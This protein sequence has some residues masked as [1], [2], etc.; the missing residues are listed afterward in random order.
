VKVAS[1]VLCSQ[2]NKKYKI[3]WWKHIKCP[4]FFSVNMWLSAWRQR[5]VLFMNMHSFDLFPPERINLSLFNYRAIKQK[6]ECNNLILLTEDRTKAYR[7]SVRRIIYQKSFILD[8]LFTTIW[9]SGAYFES[10]VYSYTFF[11][12]PTIL[13]FLLRQPWTFSTTK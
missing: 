9:T 4:Q 8:P 12:Q 2:P 6:R 11:C 7:T 10:H 5:W 13:L 3:I 1:V